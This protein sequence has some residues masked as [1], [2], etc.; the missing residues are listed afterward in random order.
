M[1]HGKGQIPFVT[2]HGKFPPQLLSDD[3]ADSVLQLLIKKPVPA[4]VLDLSCYSFVLALQVRPVADVGVLR[5]AVVTVKRAP[6]NLLC[7][8]R[9]IGKKIGNAAVTLGSIGEAGTAITGSYKSSLPG[10]TAVVGSRD[11][12]C[13]AGQNQVS[14]LVFSNDAACRAASISSNGSVYVRIIDAAL[15]HNTGNATDIALS[16]NPVRNS[17]LG[18]DHVVNQISF[19]CLTGNT[20]HCAIG[21]GTVHG[22]SLCPAVLH[23]D[24]T[25]RLLNLGSG[26]CSLSASAKYRRDSTRILL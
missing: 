22:N 5:K 20:A 24:G 6:E 9:C 19:F 18:N 7:L 8:S 13:H 11:T 2:L 16:V 4:V 12:A 26:C 21:S 14:T 17:V 23:N 10:S 3:V 1:V 15:V 25:V